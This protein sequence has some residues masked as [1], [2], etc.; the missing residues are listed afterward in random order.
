MKRLLFFI[1][2]ILFSLFLY[3]KYIE[4]IKFKIHEYT[5]NSD[6]IPDSFKELKIVH[7]SDLLY[8]KDNTKLDN[9]ITEINEL[10]ADIIFFTG[11]LFNSDNDYSEEDFNNIQD[12]LTKLNADFK[13]AITGENDEKFY[14]KFKDILYNSNFKLLDNTSD[15]LFYKDITPIKII[16]YKNHDIDFNTLL[17]SDIDYN[18]TLVLTHKP[19][20]IEYIKDYSIDTIIAGHSL[21]GIIN[22]PYYGGLIKLDGSKTY[23]NDYYKVDNT[24]LFISNGLGYKSFEFRLFN[25][26]SINVYRF[27]N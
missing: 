25:N 7:F 8:D 10:N 17:Q 13:Y 4:P 6:K 21:G 23:I 22:V 19:D 16:G 18:Y 15:L 14:D 1:I 27:N 24:E 11:D 2:I 20:N 26:P 3:G 5:I 9:Y 12:F